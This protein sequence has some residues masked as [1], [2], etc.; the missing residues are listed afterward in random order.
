MIIRERLTRWRQVN[1]YAARYPNDM[2]ISY[3]G[4][5]NY[6]RTNGH[7]VVKIPDQ[8]ASEHAAPML[9]GG[10]TVYRPLKMNGCGPGKSVA[11]AGVG[12]LGHFGILFAK[13]LGADWV[14]GIS[15][16]ESKRN[17]VLSLGADE[18]IATDDESHWEETHRRKFDLIISTVSS[19]KMP[20]NGYLKLLKTKGSLIQV[21]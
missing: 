21:G 6:N 15:R 4:Y 1:T 3:G 18:Y 19:E 7:F 2:G 12:G 8:L 11:I 13:A 9:C 5:S 10:I 14:T 20:M 17:E 16:K